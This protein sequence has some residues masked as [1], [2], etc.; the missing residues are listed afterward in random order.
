MGAVPFT[1][2]SCLP[3]LSLA[4]LVTVAGCA[5]KAQTA[6]VDEAVEAEGEVISD[7]AMTP[8]QSD[9]LPPAINEQPLGGVA[10]RG[11]APMAVKTGTAPLLYLVESAQTVQVVDETA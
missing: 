1:I 9:K 8:E 7:T 11:T 5:N 6:K 4:A 3:A 2:P 10:S